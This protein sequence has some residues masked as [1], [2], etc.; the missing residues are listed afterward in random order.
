MTWPQC[1]FER[2][3]AINEKTLGPGH[4]STAT[5]ASNLA[6]LLQTLGYY[7]EAKQ[8]Y[9]RALTILEETL[10]SNHPSTGT[11]LNNLANHLFTTGYY[12]EAKP[13]SERALA[14]S[15]KTMGI[16]HLDTIR[17]RKNHK[18]LVKFIQKAKNKKN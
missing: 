6:G 7:E 8:L 1:F 4:S 11:A 14:I 12:E 5:T 2:A 9:K 3:L 16:N 13:F 17:I 15:E 18:K 10:G